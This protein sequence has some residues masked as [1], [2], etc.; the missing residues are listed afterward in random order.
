MHLHCVGLNHLTAV[1][2]AREALA[3]P[4]EAQETALTSFALQSASEGRRDGIFEMA[5]LSTCNRTE[6]YALASSPEPTPVEDLLASITGRALSSVPG[7]LYHL[8]D[9]E[10]TT[11]LLRVAAGL[12]SM[13]LG[14]P[15]IL[16]QVA[17][18]YGRAR[19]SGSAGPVLSRLFQNAVH[20]GKRVRTETSIGV[21][22]SSIPSVIVKVAGD[23]APPN[24]S[25][26][27]L[28]VGAGEMAGLT[29]ESFRKRGVVNI[30]VLNRTPGKA[31]A[32]ASRWGGHAGALD[33][34]D[35]ELRLADVV[36]TSTSSPRPIVSRPMLKTCLA[37]RSRPH[38]LLVF[39]LAVPRDVD[40]SAS[41][42]PGL[43]L[44]DLDSLQVFLSNSLEGRSR[45]IPQIES[46]IAEGQSDFDQWFA[47]RSVVPL[48]G[49]LHS[50][51]EDLRRRELDR[52]LK[53]L[54]HLT[55]SEINEIDILTRSLVDKLLMSPTLYLKNKAQDDDLGLHQ[56][57]TR[58]LF[59]L[60]PGESY[61]STPSQN[62]RR[63]T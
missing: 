10:V 38:Q 59:G 26:R 62:G 45:E 2:S 6:L 54:T 34:L 51:A 15:Q 61:N 37:Q 41:G 48:I 5:I 55:E 50:Q 56:E 36:I 39:D 11:H 16:G 3:I 7:D 9:Q 24:G 60:E 46:M 25:R 18:A 20:M 14:E 12:D 28:V 13:V 22:P 40:A 23:I 8:T 30:T 58:Q 53:H 47:T 43:Q 4:A 33:E 1:L 21:N 32:L 17:D 19:R 49:E 44:F 52:S 31:A 63:T 27:V 29:V 42:L 35:Q 57:V